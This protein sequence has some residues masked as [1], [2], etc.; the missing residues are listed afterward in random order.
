[1]IGGALVAL[2]YLYLRRTPALAILAVVGVGALSV[3]V[4]VLQV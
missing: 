3:A 2:A 1:L 4:A